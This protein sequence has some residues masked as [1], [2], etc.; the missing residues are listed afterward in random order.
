MGTDCLFCKIVARAIP[1][2]I[3]HENDHVLAFR[4]VRPVAP[5]HALVVPKKHVA[6]I[7]DAGKEDV[8]LLGELLLAARDVAEQLGLG[9]DGYR[10]VVN[11]GPNAGQSV[12][13][14]HV[15]VLGGRTMSWPPG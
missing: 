13:H 10:I 12:F 9:S 7:H 14:I 3:V 5:T 8:A 11:Q 2:Q 4:D 6:G 1:A 15:H